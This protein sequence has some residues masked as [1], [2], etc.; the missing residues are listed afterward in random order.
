MNEDIVR[1]DKR[2]ERVTGC[3]QVVNMRVERDVLVSCTAASYF[4]FPFSWTL[5]FYFLSN[6]KGLGKHTGYGLYRHTCPIIRSPGIVPI[7]VNAHN[8][9][10]A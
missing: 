3:L 8:L 9:F 4:F 2:K 10:A 7:V 1:V 6:C 5:G